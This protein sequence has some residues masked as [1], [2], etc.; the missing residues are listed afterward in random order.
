MLALLAQTAP[1]LPLHHPGLFDLWKAIGVSTLAIS[2]ASTLLW[3]AIPFW[4]RK[5]YG[6]LENEA[7]IMATL[8]QAPSGQ[9]ALPAVDW[10]RVDADRKAEIRKGPIGYL[11]LRNPGEYSAGKALL[12]YFGFLALVMVF[13][14]YV[15]GHT[16]P[17]GAHY[18]H[19]YRLAGA[20]TT[21]A[22]AFHTVPDSIWRGKPWAAT[23]EQFI[24][25]L[26]YGMVVGGMF[27][28]LW[29]K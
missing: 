14:A 20:C 8:T 10:A 3:V 24:D 29:P 18:R 28:W 27:G 13:V 6:R 25:S 5:G 11:V 9:W 4:R 1:D 16:L 21:L 22:F 26:V 19:V 12:Q 17:F 7:D 23:L 15:V 2:V